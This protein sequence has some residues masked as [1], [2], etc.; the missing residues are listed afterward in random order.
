M[1]NVQAKGRD[2][3]S[4]SRLSALLESILGASLNETRAVKIGVIIFS[5]P[6]MLAILYVSCKSPI[7]GIDN[8]KNKLGTGNT[9]I[10]NAE[11]IGVNNIV[12]IMTNT[13]I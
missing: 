4:A 3:F 5:G 8:K 12:V 6:V 7:T 2:A 10:T 11:N 9:T 1:P 13:E